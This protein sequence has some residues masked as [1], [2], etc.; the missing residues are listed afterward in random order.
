V[1]ARRTVGRLLAAGAVALAVS[2]PLSAAPASADP[3]ITRLV[4]VAVIDGG[5][6]LVYEVP[7]GYVFWPA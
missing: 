3:D 6:Y 5:T 2:V 7:G 4:G 1:T